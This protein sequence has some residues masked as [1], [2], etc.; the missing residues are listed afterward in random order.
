MGDLKKEIERI[1]KEFYKSDQI[2]GRNI[3][4]MA[5]RINSSRANM[6]SGESDQVVNPKEPDFPGVYT[7][8]ENLVGKRSSA[9]YRAESD[10]DVMEKIVKYPDFEKDSVYILII[11]DKKSGVYDIIEKRYGEQKTETYGYKYNNEKL[12]SLSKGDE[13]QKDDILY[14][15]TSFDEDMNYRLGLNAKVMYGSDPMS[16]EDGMIFSRTFSRRMCHIEYDVVSISINDNDLM[17]NWYGDKKFYKAHPDI[18][19]ELKDSTLAGLRRI[20]YSRAFYDL[21]D[22]NMRKEL[23]SDTAFYVPFSKDKV[24]DINI[25]CNKNPDEIPE[26]PYNRQLLYYIREQEKYYKKLLK[27]LENIV[28]NEEY[29]DDLAFMYSR[30]KKI[31][32]DEYVWEDQNKKVFGNIKMEFLIE[33]GVSMPKGGKACGRYFNLV[34][35]NSFNCWNYFINKSA[36]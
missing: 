28:E 21:K 19:E 14:R 29:T 23:S 4:T 20:D 13:I 18:G 22:E 26:T 10:Y 31:C 25:R 7:N 17:L 30:V 27:V 11:K 5:N 32:D 3:M 1:N 16:I 35:I 6:F 34:T 8:Y 2:L 33:K 36:A 15:S 9:Y 24:V 12:D